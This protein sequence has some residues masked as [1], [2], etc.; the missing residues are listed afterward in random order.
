MGGWEGCLDRGLHPHL[1]RDP[2]WVGSISYFLAR[3]KPRVLLCVYLYVNRGE[4][5]VEHFFCSAFGL[6][7]SCKGP[8]GEVSI[9]PLRLPDEETEAQHQPS[10]SQHC[11]MGERQSSLNPTSHRAQTHSQLWAIPRAGGCEWQSLASVASMWLGAAPGS[12][13]WPWCNLLLPGCS[14]TRVHFLLWWGQ[15]WGHR[16]S[17]ECSQAAAF[18]D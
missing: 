13:G 17:N 15:C 16:R 6:P 9:I 3:M 18:A 4:K 10:T 5:K 12:A 2:S 11:L 14:L 1:P 8:Y 7:Q